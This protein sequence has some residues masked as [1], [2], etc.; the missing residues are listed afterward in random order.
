MMYNFCFFGCMGVNVEL[1][2]AGILH[3]CGL[4]IVYRSR[5]RHDKNR[6]KKL[7][8]LKKKQQK[9]PLNQCLCESL[10][11]LHSAGV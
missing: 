2:R 9:E 5:Y 11:C 4:N 7:C 3:D 6:T 10:E 1:D 8:G